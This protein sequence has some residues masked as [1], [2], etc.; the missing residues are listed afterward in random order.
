MIPHKIILD[1]DPGH[2]DAVAIL[3]AA[4]HPA[5]E[6]LAITTVAGNQSVE[7]TTANALKVCALADIRHVPIAKGAEKP[8]RGTPTFADNIHGESGMDGPTL[9]E[10]TMQVSP[11]HAVD[12]MI[13]LLLQSQ[14]DITLVLTGP[15]TNLALAMQREPAIVP[16]IKQIV[17]MGGAIGL[18]NVTPGAEFNV[19]FDP[20]A[21]AQ[22]FACGRPL[23]MVPLEVTHQALAT[24]EILQQLQASGRPVPRFV[25]DLLTYFAGTYQREFGFPAAPVH[26]PC[27]V[28]ALIDPAIIETREMR[29]EI[30][31]G[32]EWSRGRTVCDVYG[33]LGKAPNARVGYQLHAGRFW[34]LVLTTL[35]AYA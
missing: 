30:E 4:R 32:G 17:V 5:I 14:G 9:P 7:K 2:D 8:L 15:F 12:L 3:L 27:T 25:A 6:L 26:D 19:W 22:V 21:A 1:C 33:K 11:L 35:L 28:A 16:K 13:S 24:E 18:G 31:T 10:A 23:L 29:V 34:E 20:E